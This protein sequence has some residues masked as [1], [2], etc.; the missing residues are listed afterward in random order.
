MSSS[1]TKT[2]LWAGL[3]T[4]TRGLSFV[5]GPDQKRLEIVEIE[6]ES[7]GVLDEHLEEVDKAFRRVIAGGLIWFFKRKKLM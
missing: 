1:F 3:L 4:G 7:R 5:L 2:R 6:H